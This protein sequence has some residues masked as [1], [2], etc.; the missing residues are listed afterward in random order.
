MDSEQAAEDA[1]MAPKMVQRLCLLPAVLLFLFPPAHPFPDR[2]LRI[3]TGWDSSSE[4]SC[5]SY[6]GAP[7]M[8]SRMA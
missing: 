8:H 7:G 4:T 6:F 1:P 3:F 2:T 5:A